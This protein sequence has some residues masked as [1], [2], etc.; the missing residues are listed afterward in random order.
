MLGESS[1]VRGSE[2]THFY[3]EASE[4][5]MIFEVSVA[6]PASAL[7]LSRGLGSSTPFWSFILPPL[8]FS[9]TSAYIRV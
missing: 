6:P 7:A 2:V 5:H 9:E 4:E 3:C 1:G 8:R